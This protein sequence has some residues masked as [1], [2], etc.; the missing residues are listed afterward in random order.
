MA[1]RIVDRAKTVGRILLV[2]FGADR[3]DQVCKHPKVRCAARD[4]H[5]ARKRAGLSG[6]EG[7]GFDEFFGAGVNA[8]RDGIQYLAPRF[9]RHLGPYLGG[10]L[11]GDDGVVDHFPGGFV[12]V[13]E[14]RAVDRR[15]VLE[16]VSAGD[17][18]TADKILK[19]AN[20]ARA[21]CG[22]VSLPDGSEAGPSN[23]LV[24]KDT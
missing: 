7:F 17:E 13:R 9:D 23:V 2:G 24:S 5:V 12:H 16:G 15:G 8:V 22:H 19:F 11:R 3:F 21:V 4:V 10:L 1:D 6:I 18:F 14:Q 20:V